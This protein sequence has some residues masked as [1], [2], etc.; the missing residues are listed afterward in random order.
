MPATRNTLATAVKGL[1]QDLVPFLRYNTEGF[2]DK[3]QRVGVLALIEPSMASADKE[4]NGKIKED[5]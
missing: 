2:F 1:Q 5:R 3:V 4:S